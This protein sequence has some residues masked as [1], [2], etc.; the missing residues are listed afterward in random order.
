MTTV[1]I[2]KKEYR[3]LIDMKDKSKKKRT[4]VAAGFGALKNSFGKK[5]SSSYVSAM[6]KSWRA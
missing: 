6:R 4:F 1:T 3:E 5:T 2:P